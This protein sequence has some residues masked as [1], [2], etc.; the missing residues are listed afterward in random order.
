[1]RLAIINTHPIQY[2]APVF[3]LLH[4]QKKPQH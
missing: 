1:M 4:L 2:Y 3:K